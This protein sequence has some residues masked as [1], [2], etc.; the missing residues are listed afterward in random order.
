MVDC[1]QQ[2]DRTIPLVHVYLDPHF[3]G[4]GVLVTPAGSRVACCPLRHR[5]LSTAADYALYLGYSVQVHHFTLPRRFW[6]VLEPYP[7]KPTNI[8]PF[9][10]HKACLPPV[11]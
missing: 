3:I 1:T 10:W 9:A 8:S 5:S 7:E 4:R 11:E 6:T 2:A